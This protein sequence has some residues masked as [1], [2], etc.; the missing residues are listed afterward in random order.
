MS[1]TCIEEDCNK[2]PYYGKEHYKPLHCPEHRVFQEINVVLPWCEEKDCKT[3]PIYNFPN[4]KIPIFCNSHKKE[5]MVNIITSICTFQ[6]CKKQPS[7]GYPVSKEKFRCSEHKED[8]MIDV[9]HKK[10]LHQGCKSIPNFN[11]EGLF[12][13][14]YCKKHKEPNMVDVVHKKCEQMGCYKRP[15]YGIKGTKNDQFCSKHKEPGMVDINHKLCIIKECDTRA[16][17]GTPGEKKV[18]FCAFHKDE[19]MENHNNKCKEKECKITSCFNYPNE[20]KGIY[21]LTHKLPG[22]IDVKN[23]MCKCGKRAWYGTPGLPASSCAEHRTE[24]MI[25][26]PRS[27]CV[28]S[29]CNNQSIYGYTLPLHCES[30]RR[31][32]EYNLVER[33]CVNCNLLDVLDDKKH[34][35]QCGD[36][37]FRRVHLAKQKEIKALLDSNKI[38]YES[39]DRVIDTQCGL[40][41][42]DFLI[43]CKTHK[44]VLEVD[45][46]QHNSYNEDCERV[47][48][49]NIS[50]SLGMPVIFLRYNPDKFKK[51]FKFDKRVTKK[52]KQGFLLEWL[53]H[54][55]TMEPEN[56]HEFLR[57]VYLFFDNFNPGDIPVQN[58]NI[59]N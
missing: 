14:V 15:N 25:K 30:H 45:E 20:L 49:I 22:M 59:L 52:Y 42:P 34:C 4:E 21:C 38:K 41:R 10:C 31:D 51:P 53:N 47:R 33:L 39:Y 5:E 23:I 18:S 11:N 26:Y 19:E 54:I 7:Y 17:Y 16:S 28:N 1:N 12:I 13:G 29:S 36:F 6:D 3:I 48:M 57:V 40:E 24:N 56:E 43:D 2:I 58:I 37:K 32:D 46:N 50:Q 44:V 8:G 35:S 27:R 9:T 55:K